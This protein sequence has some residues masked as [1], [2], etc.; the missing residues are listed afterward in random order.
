M[1]RTIS[2]SGTERGAVSRIPQEPGQYP[3]YSVLADTSLSVRGGIW[4]FLR[5]AADRKGGA[6]KN[7]WYLLVNPDK[8]VSGIGNLMN[9]YGTDVLSQMRDWAVANY[10]DDA[11][12]VTTPPAF[13]NLSWNTRSVETYVNATNQK[14]GTTFPLKT[15]PLLNTQIPISLAD[16]GARICA[17]R[18]APTLSAARR[19]SARERFPPPSASP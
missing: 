8:N 6:E 2:R 11:L 18:S 5:Y 14:N 13:Q 10:L 19:S 3:P 7:T 17:S 1:A 4:S 12:S 15:Q 16:G 9:V